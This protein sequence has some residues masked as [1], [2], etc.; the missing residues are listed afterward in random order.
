M[1][2]PARV[3][4]LK[5][6]HLFHGLSDHEL[7]TVAQLLQEQTIEKGAVIFTEGS[8]ADSVHIIFQGKVNLSQ[9]VKNKTQKVAS[10]G[11]GDYYGEM[12]MLRG[13]IREVTAVSEEA[14]TIFILYRKTLT[15]LLKKALHFQKN[16]QCILSSRAL[17]NQLHFTWLAENEIIY[18]LGR[19]HWF[20]LIRALLMP[21]LLLIPIFGLG[22][23]AFIFD[24]A[25]IGLIVGFFLVLD[26]AWGAWQYVD[27]GNDYY[28]VTNQ[29]VIWLEK[30]I[31]FYDSRT[32]AGMNVILSVNRDTDYFGRIFNYGSVIVRT[33][34]GQ[35]RMN[36]VDHP[37]MAAAIIEEL[38]GRAKESGRKAGEE[39]MKQ[40]IRQKLGFTKP[41][42]P[43]AAGS[44]KAAPSRP[45]QQVRKKNIWSAWWENAFRMRTEDGNVITYHKHIFGFIRDASPYSLGIVV[46]AIGTLIWPFLMGSYLPLWV[47][48]LIAS[49][50]VVLFGFV[51][52]QYLDWK[53]DVYQVTPD[54]IID[55]SRK[56]LGSEIRR[57]AP[58]ENILSTE[59]TR[60]GI[61][62]LFLNFGTVFIKI[63]TENFDFVDVADP[64]SVQQDII[65]RQQGLTQKK[66]EKEI[67]AEQDRMTDWLAMYHRTLDEV[68]R[69]KGQKQG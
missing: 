52:Y 45:A 64:P 41:E 3:D 65:S 8:T 51:V 11:K 1:D 61:L 38:L 57:A 47:L 2:I 48:T 6:L 26:F 30:V 33:Y 21:V 24:S 10:L 62:G 60:S 46:L 20:L 13:K 14:T 27:W 68:E 44:E 23:L 4:F 15:P 37:S 35:I 29:R 7:A 58:L 55:I 53:N 40:A 34:T 32:E 49:G 16:I 22:G 39:A 18:F 36:F 69:E 42:P 50:I 43:P 66:R 5:K 17:A 63:G 56:P 28:I 12:G 67:R 31:A 19:K 9:T 59:N 54:Q 25:G